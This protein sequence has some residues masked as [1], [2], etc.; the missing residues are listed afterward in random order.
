MSDERIVIAEILRERGNKGEV[1]ARSVSDVPGRIESLREAQLRMADGTDE[2]ATVEAAWSH[3]GDWVLKFA[4]VDSID[5]AKRLRG[6]DVW[7]PKADRGSLP[8]GEYF[9]SDLVGCSVVDQSDGRILGVV[10]GLEQ[11]GGPPLLEVKGEVGEVL[12]PFVPA[13]CVSVDL[14]NRSISVDLP[15]GLLDL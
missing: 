10:E 8:E 1:I 14:V 12:I 9:Q 4:G 13:I 7:L 3:K 2:V 11:Y 6:A 15:E 5:S